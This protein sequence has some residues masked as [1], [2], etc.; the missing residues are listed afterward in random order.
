MAQVRRLRAMALA[1]LVM[2][3]SMAGPSLAAP[4]KPNGNP[5]LGPASTGIQ[6]PLN[7]E[8]YMADLA[9]RLDPACDKSLLLK[10]TRASAIGSA[11]AA[12]SGR[13]GSGLSSPARKTAPDGQPRNVA[14]GTLANGSGLYT[15]PPRQP[16]NPA[17]GRSAEAVASVPNRVSEPKPVTPTTPALGDWNGGATPNVTESAAPTRQT[18]EAVPAQAGRYGPYAPAA[19]PS[20][21]QPAGQAQNGANNLTVQGPVSVE[22]QLA[23]SKPGLSLWSEPGAADAAAPGTAGGPPE[24]QMPWTLGGD[25]E[26]Y[27]AHAVKEGSRQSGANLKKALERAGMTLGD[28]VNIFVLGYASDR[29][30]PFRENDGKGLL[31]EPGKVPARAGATIVSLGDGL[32]S[33]ADLVTFNALPDPNKAAYRE[34]NPIVRP[35]IYTGRTIGGAWK[36]AEEV[37]N[38]VTW[39]LFDNFTGCVGLVIEDIVEFLKHAGQAVTNVARAPIRLVAGQKNEG[40]DRAMDWVLLVPLELASNAVE[41]KGIS[42]M[43]DYKTAFADK[44]VIGSV[45]ELGG[46]TYVVYRAADELLD[47]H[48]NNKN[49]ASRNESS[50]NQKPAAQPT[51]DTTQ[52]PS[53]PA[54]PTPPPIFEEPPPPPA[55]LEWVFTGDVIFVD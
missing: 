22:R 13:K 8:A 20:P 54:P 52:P 48:K 29:A 27:R 32:Y 42:N 31:Q 23:A 36:T 18:M 26:K 17:P 1:G 12:P 38:A 39:G 11:S 9:A 16:S 10:G 46:S 19:M 3:A 21:G 43:A 2:A 15:A 41:M 33:I 5:Q 51:G 24:P 45:L 55:D 44:G 53:P 47:R 25:L 14:P 49:N 40:A 37:G 28:G 34:N 30:K 4:K 7:A 35:L 50:Q 6:D